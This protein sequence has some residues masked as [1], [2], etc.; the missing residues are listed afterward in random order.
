[1]AC[2]FCLLSDIIHYSRNEFD[3]S[4]A[5][6][7]KRCKFLE[8]ESQYLREREIEVREDLCRARAENAAISAELKRT[9]DLYREALAARRSTRDA[10][11]EMAQ[12]NARLVSAY[13]EKKQEFRN[14]QV[15][16]VGDCSAFWHLAWYIF[17]GLMDEVIA[18]SPS[19]AVV[20]MLGNG[21]HPLVRIL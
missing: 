12:Q 6:M 8:A 21:C 4:I 5:G 13:V 7:M 1:M 18:H 9:H 14:L 10:L 17:V 2:S 16:P 20:S 19:A 3:S 15:F 11:S